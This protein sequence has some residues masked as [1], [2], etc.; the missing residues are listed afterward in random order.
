MQGLIQPRVTA[1]SGQG[2]TGVI[3]IKVM[4][5]LKEFGPIERGALLLIVGVALLI[6][7]SGTGIDSHKAGPAPL[8]LA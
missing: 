3:I 2:W 4:M 5:S 7:Q 8:M 1:L 6:T